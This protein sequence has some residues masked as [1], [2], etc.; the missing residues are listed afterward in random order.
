MCE[1]MAGPIKINDLVP[2]LWA[3]ATSRGITTLDWLQAT[4]PLHYQLTSL[5]TRHAVRRQDR[6]VTGVGVNVQT[7]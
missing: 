5:T 4:P 7:D 1:L 2:Q 6:S 3:A